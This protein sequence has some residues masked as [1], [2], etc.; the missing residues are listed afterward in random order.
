[1]ENQEVGQQDQER[2]RER[3]SKPT[4][5]Q[6]WLDN[7]YPTGEEKSQL[8]EITIGWRDEFKSN[9]PL[10]KEQAKELKG[11][12]LDLSEYPNLEEVW[13]WGNYL[14]SPL[15]ELELGE[16]PKLT[17]L[18]CARNQLASL[19]LTNCPNLEKVQCW[20]NKLT[21][22]E[23]GK[24]EKLAILGCSKNQLTTLNLN[25]CQKLEDINCS[26]NQLTNL[27]VSS[28]SALK[29]LT[30]NKNQLSELKL[31]SQLEEI[32][33]SENNL[34]TLHSSGNQINSLDLIDCSRLK[35][36][37][38]YNNKLKELNLSN[39]NKLEVVKCWNN[40]LTKLDL[41]KSEKLIEL[42][43]SNNQLTQLIL[44][45]NATNLQT[46]VCFDNSLTKL[47]FSM[48][49][50]EKLTTLDLQN[51][52]F[53]TKDWD[54]SLFA[55]FTQLKEL[56]LGA[57]SARNNYDR[58]TGS[59]KPL[60]NLTNLETLD[61]RNTDINSGWEY[62][63]DSLRKLNCSA[64]QRENAKCQVIEK[65]FKSFGLEKDTNSLPENWRQDNK[66]KI[67]KKLQESNNKNQEN[68]ELLNTSSELKDEWTSRGFTGKEIERWIKAGFSPYE[69]TQV[70]EWEDLGFNHEEASK[71]RERGLFVDDYNFAYYLKKKKYKPEDD[72]DLK[73]KEY[74]EN[75]K[76]KSL[77]VMR[78]MAKFPSE[79]GSLADEVKN[80]FNSENF[81][82]Q[83]KSSN[84]A[85]ET[86]LDTLKKLC[87]IIA[88]CQSE[89][90]K[91]EICN[92]INDIM[93]YRDADEGNK[94][95][96][97]DVHEVWT[98][99]E[100]EGLI[101]KKMPRHAEK[102]VTLLKTSL[103]SK[104]KQKATSSSP[105]DGKEEKN[106]KKKH[107]DKIYPDLSE[108]FPWTSNGDKALELPLKLLYIGKLKKMSQISDHEIKIKSCVK[109]EED[110]REVADIY[111]TLSY[112]WGQKKRDE[113]LSEG[114]KRTLEKAI[115][116]CKLLDI[117]WL[118]MDQLCIDQENNKEKAQE[119]AK[120]GQYYG[121]S[122]VTLVAIHWDIDEKTLNELK[123]FKKEEK[124]DE[125][126]KKLSKLIEA[127]SSIL[128]R[129]VLSEWFQRSW[130]FQEGWLSKQTIFMF[131]NV[132][133]DGRFLA[134]AWKLKQS[135]LPW[136][137]TNQTSQ[138]TGNL[139]QENK[140][141]SEEKYND[142]KDFWKKE[143]GKV[144]TP[145]GWVCY[146]DEKGEGYK[147]WDIVFLRLN[148]ALRE[149][150]E[151][152]RFLAIDG[153]YSILGL[154]PY[155]K[156]V[157]IDY[158]GTEN[159]QYTKEE[160]RKALTDVLKTA[161]EHGHGDALGWHGLGSRI[162]GFCWTPRIDEYGST[163]IENYLNIDC[164]VPEQVGFKS[165]G[166]EV[167]GSEYIIA[168]VKDR[169]KN[170]VQY[171]TKD[172]FY[173]LEIKV[174]T[175]EIKADE[176]KETFCQDCKYCEKC[177]E[178]KEKTKRN[179]NQEEETITLTGTKD[180]LEAIEEGNVLI[181]LGKGEWKSDKPFAILATKG[182]GKLR[183][184]VGLVEI[185][186]GEE[187]LKGSQ[188][189]KLVIGDD[190]LGVGS[191][192][193]EKNILETK[194]EQQTPQIIQPTYGTPGSSGGNH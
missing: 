46:L 166:I 109:K 65:E 9:L 45:E 94:K 115:E 80:I 16:K 29:K 192:E 118:W 40:Q 19:N 18:I 119:V 149:M 24:L 42:R 85:S 28:C 191:F 95:W 49:N 23:L 41:S 7:K 59:L 158:L 159:H 60:K 84:E 54:L 173:E 98:D 131:D 71:W 142:L 86:K 182:K 185:L 135:S 153:I 66:Y 165:D 88:N 6:E 67:N 78:N 105:E 188:R 39:N 77:Q 81:D 83:T 176:V 108:D 101:G 181:L 138:D 104:K 72:L 120:M 143:V 189:K 13:I 102:F 50:P 152:K 123:S 128:E 31:N 150:R 38:C 122:A 134:S 107:Y 3:E 44:P 30:C 141:T 127:S 82:E 133:V 32:D 15:T 37:M 145:I 63:P 151:R 130:T 111:A 93:S 53:T 22:L 58:W 132:L 25:N 154:L 125:I 90:Q 51:N 187:K 155:G 2:E 12:K 194:Q 106:I 70:K 100:G 169:E 161:M 171:K 160:I 112:V 116:A 36:I 61:I 48:F 183:H 103:E 69:V 167:F 27:D 168:H 35:E 79:L 20:Q 5:L 179:S 124:E 92:C 137:I 180:A 96:A 163:N 113:L 10:T 97:W 164:C 56:D 126:V 177:L 146:R 114:G 148:E 140:Q 17:Y 55:N 74:E 136:E 11:G 57:Y 157:K 162:H 21:E 4:T 91:K 43:C 1:M 68:Q 184:R 193:R 14:K 178:R 139:T 89:C 62:L 64:K 110:I 129:I 190:C 117:D 186:E 144:A 170:K 52:N 75:K 87:R 73:K 47:D 175:D 172:N 8:K 174:K 156:E 121:N 33:C 76:E 147:P 34:T 26:N 99:K